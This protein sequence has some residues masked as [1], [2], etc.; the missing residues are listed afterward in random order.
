[1][2]NAL[3]SG[4]SDVFG[5]GFVIRD[6]F[7]KTTLDTAI[8]T[9]GST[10]GTPSDPTIVSD[11]AANGIG[12]VR[13]LSVGISGTSFIYSPSVKIGTGDFAFSSRVRVTS[14]GDFDSGGILGNNS[15]EV[16]G[17]GSVLHI[18]TGVTNWYI[19]SSGVLTS[20]AVPWGSTYQQINVH[21]LSGVVYVF[22]DGVKVFS[23]ANTQDFSSAALRAECFSG[24]AY[25]GSMY[26]DTL[27]LWVGR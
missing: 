23:A 7:L 2:I 22:I 17:G 6:E 18:F 10:G 11:G 24:P 4:V 8:W 13:P 15:F 25:N 3:F 20:L 16:S 19:K 5:S 14:G 1:M 27:A 21:R 9:I 26:N 12:A